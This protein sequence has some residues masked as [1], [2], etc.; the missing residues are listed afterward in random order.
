MNNKTEQSHAATNHPSTSLLQDEYLKGFQDSKRKA[1]IFLLN[2]VRLEGVIV[3]F[4]RYVV[5][6]DKDGATDGSPQ[7][8]MIY[9]HAIATVQPWTAKPYTKAAHTHY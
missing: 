4:D 6:I 9:K 5:I 7:G 8:Q 1:Y 2:G 3:R